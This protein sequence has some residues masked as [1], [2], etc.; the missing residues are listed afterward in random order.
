MDQINEMIFLL[1]FA[2]EEGSL[3]HDLKFI[4]IHDYPL[5][6]EFGSDR[7]IEGDR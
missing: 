3:G 2:Y 7:Q 4:F 6:F 1:S 5:F